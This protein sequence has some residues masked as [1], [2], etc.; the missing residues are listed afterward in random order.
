MRKRSKKRVFVL[1]DRHKLA[2]QI[3]AQGD[4]V[5]MQ[6]VADR[7][8]VHRSTLWRWLQ[9][10]EFQRYCERARC[11]AV[12]EAMKDI[13]REARE[14]RREILRKEREWEKQKRREKKAENVRWLIEHGAPEEAIREYV[15]KKK[16][17]K[18]R[19]R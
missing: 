8:G 5:T 6:E 19:F 11:A 18:K 13:E 2:A 1:D 10:R 16:S 17:E 12:A 3:F 9:H 7:V 4:F 15:G 14:M